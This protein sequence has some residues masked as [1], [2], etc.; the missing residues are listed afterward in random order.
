MY[1]FL[2]GWVKLKDWNIFNVCGFWWKWY[3]WSSWEKLI[4]EIKLKFW[5]IKIFKFGL[6]FIWCIK[7]IYCFKNKF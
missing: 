3:I 5:Y 4:L 2:N 6:C 7:L 1:M